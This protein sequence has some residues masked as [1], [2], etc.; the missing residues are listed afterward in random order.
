M[1]EPPELGVAATQ[2]EFVRST[3][4]LYRFAIIPNMPEQ[5]PVLAEL[6]EPE[7]WS[8][9]HSPTD[10]ELPILFNYLHHTFDRIEEEPAQAVAPWPSP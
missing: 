2:P 1:E 5:L 4:P 3:R 6:A 7:D 10:H 9:R 8:Y